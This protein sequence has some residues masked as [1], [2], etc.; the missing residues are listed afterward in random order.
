MA[1]HELL[2]ER[3]RARLGADPGFTEKRMSGGLAFL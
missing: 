3:I 2:A 1:F